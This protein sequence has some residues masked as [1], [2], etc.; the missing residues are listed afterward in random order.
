MNSLA[1]RTGNYFDPFSGLSRDMTQAFFGTNPWAGF[2]S[3]AGSNHLRPAFRLDVYEGPEAWKVV[4]EVAGVNRD[5]IALR[6]EDDALVIELTV[7]PAEASTAEPRKYAR[8]VRFDGTVDIDKVVA[9]YND[10]HLTVVLPKAEETRP[11]EITI[12]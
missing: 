4:S 6:Y 8:T 3:P 5:D 2:F 12:Q 10:G 11:R 7:K 9:R 1:N